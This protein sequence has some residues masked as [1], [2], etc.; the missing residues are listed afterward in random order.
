MDKILNQISKNLK[1]RYIFA[2][3]SMALI[4]LISQ[5][6]LQI[7]IYQQKED[8]K[9]INLAG[10]Q[11]MLSQR[12]VKKVLYHEYDK[13]VFPSIESEL[14]EFSY[15][16]EY[17]MNHASKSSF[18]M[19]SLKN[20]FSKLQIEL[21]CFLI[22]CNGEKIQTIKNINNFSNTFL[23][24]QN[25]Y[26]NHLEYLNK[27]KVSFLSTIE[28]TLFSIGIFTLLLE[29]FLILK[30]SLN[31]LKETLLAHEEEQ[32]AISKLYKKAEIAD[33]S[34]SIFHEI[35]NNLSV[36]KFAIK[37]ISKE[38]FRTDRLKKLVSNADISTK[39][40][41]S[42][43]LSA[44]KV[45]R[46]NKTKEITNFNTFLDDYENIITDLMRTN[47]VKL[48]IERNTSELYVLMNTPEILQVLL[49]LSRNSIHAME[50][51]SDKFINI[52]TTEDDDNIILAF[53]DKGPG[54]PDDVVDKMFDEYFTTK[55][56]EQGTG[57]GMSIS[58]KI[59]K[60]HDSSINYATI[61][62]HTTFI[63]KFPKVAKEEKVA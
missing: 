2:L 58:E 43:V 52:K 24:N 25:K 39:N 34:N 56:S 30:P 32:K 36:I 40:L 26:V 31:N 13:S 50:N 12:L 59:L 14:S 61:N 38:E 20:D 27:E 8:G 53:Q 63:L 44:N 4:L 7:N 1:N 62:G 46:E 51:M 49:N 41:E 18:D 19:E 23:K 3:G 47:N 35:K 21:D 55:S 6:I 5:V 17:L 45:A 10:K 29:F 54:I 15:N 60:N 11:R 9:F 37:K 28:Y 57:L 22:N 42:L 48:N 16:Q 33:L